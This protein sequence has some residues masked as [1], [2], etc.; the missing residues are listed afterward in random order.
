MKQF[1]RVLHVGFNPI[2]APTNT[3][4][5]LASMFDGWPRERLFEVYSPSRQV[6]EPAPNRL[7]H[8]MAVAPM[9]AV[10][11]TLLGARVPRPASDGMNNSISRKGTA[12][13]LRSRLRTAATTIND[14]GPV[15]VAGRWLSPV[16]QFQPEVIHSLLGGVRVTKLVLSLADR[17]A[18]PIVPHFMDDWPATLFA[19]GRTFGVPRRQ[20]ESL[21]NRVLER[22]PVCLT[23]GEDMEYEFAQRFSRPCVTVGNSVDLHD[24]EVAPFPRASDVRI[25]RYMGGLHLGRDRV[26][27]SLVEVLDH[28][29]EARNA[30]LVVNAPASDRERLANLASRWPSRVEVGETVDPREVPRLLKS[31]DALVFVESSDPDVLR[32]TRLSVSTKVPEYLS[33]GRPVI[34]LGPQEQSSVRALRLGPAT[35]HADPSDADALMR[36]VRESLDQSKEFIAPPSVE[37]MEVFDRAKTQERLRLALGSAAAAGGGL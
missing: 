17:Y 23:I 16:D 15:W 10:A 36:V 34:A 32:F 28:Q 1:P 14:I 20:V 30:K 3:G 31:C 7:V 18:V 21:I 9:D 27:E 12:Q 8:P 11:R 4:L 33:A 19:D 26:L 29:A 22:A 2:G 35:F 5:T 37:V 25:L 6:Y 24:F 13:S